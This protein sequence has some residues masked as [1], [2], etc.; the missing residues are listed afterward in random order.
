MTSCA[1]GRTLPI[2]LDIHGISPKPVMWMPT[3]SKLKRH[4]ITESTSTPVTTVTDCVAL[5]QAAAPLF[6][7]VNT[8]LQTFNTSNTSSANGAAICLTACRRYTPAQPQYQPRCNTWNWC[9]AT[10]C[11]YAVNATANLTLT[12]QTCLLGYSQA[13]ALNQPLGAVNTN[14][15]GYYSGAAVSSERLTIRG[16]CGYAS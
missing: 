10:S 3:S 11:T 9:N 7:Q 6:V 13:A 5:L 8:V 12:G 15:S 2:G 4:S 16:P 1:A 14:N